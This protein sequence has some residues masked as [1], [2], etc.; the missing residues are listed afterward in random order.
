MKAGFHRSHMRV[1]RVDGSGEKIVWGSPEEKEKLSGK[2][3]HKNISLASI[4]EVVPG[5]ST[6]A[7]SNVTTPSKAA[8]CFTIYA[9][10]RS[11]DVE[12]QDVISKNLWV[13][14]LNDICFVYKSV[15]FHS[16]PPAH[17]LSSHPSLSFLLSEQSGGCDG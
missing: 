15:P 16:H 8:C 10:D 5:A 13:S 9:E 4:I 1:M 6:Q 14:N 17:P 7:L 2:D 12:M 3:D 11:L